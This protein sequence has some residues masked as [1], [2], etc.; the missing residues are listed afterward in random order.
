M[1]TQAP[2]WGPVLTQRANSVD[3]SEFIITKTT[4]VASL[5]NLGLDYSQA[6]QIHQ[7]GKFPRYKVYLTSLESNKT[8]KFP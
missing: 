6:L 7:K 1:H 4:Q 3:M 8:S 5:Q 2:T